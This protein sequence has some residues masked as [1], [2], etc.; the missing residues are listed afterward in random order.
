[1]SLRR[2]SRMALRYY[3]QC[4]LTAI[5]RESA[6]RISPTATAPSH[7]PPAVLS[8]VLSCKYQRWK[9]YNCVRAD[10]EVRQP[11]QK[12]NTPS[13]TT[14]LDTLVRRVAREQ[15]HV[16]RLHGERE[17][18]EERTVDAHHCTSGASERVVPTM[19]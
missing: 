14:H 10:R 3:T 13:S 18:H 12:S 16:A 2:E 15:Q 4:Q 9:L 5:D 17:A 11:S 6:L 1:M 8:A 7:P 19:S